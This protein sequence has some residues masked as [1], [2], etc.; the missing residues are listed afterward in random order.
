MIC[1]K[2]GANRNE[3]FKSLR[4]GIESDNWQYAVKI[5]H[6]CKECAKAIEAEIDFLSKNIP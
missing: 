4:E 6:N 1:P 3:L 2:C 5:I